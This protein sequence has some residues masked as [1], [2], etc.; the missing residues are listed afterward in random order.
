M[1]EGGPDNICGRLT[2]IIN[3][4]TLTFKFKSNYLKMGIDLLQECD[5]IWKKPKNSTEVTLF[6]LV[7]ASQ[8]WRS[9][10]KHWGSSIDRYPS[11]PKDYVKSI[12]QSLTHLNAKLIEWYNYADEWPTD[13]QD[14][15]HTILL[16]LQDIINVLEAYIEWVESPEWKIN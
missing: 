3:L 13:I 1:W 4:L 12:I 7:Y 10:S 11:L 5:K 16:D 6:P 15:L 8:H 9:I 14:I 2:K